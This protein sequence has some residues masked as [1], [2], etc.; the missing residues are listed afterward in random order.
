VKT[1]TWLG[2]VSRG[3]APQPLPGRD[4]QGRRRWDADE[5]RSFPRPGVGRSRAGASPEAEALLAQ[6]REVA[7]AIEELRGRQRE[8]LAEGKRQGL[9]VLA[10]SRALGISRQT[11]YAWLGD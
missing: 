7:D 4:E 1:T 8:L 6:M 11:A 10:M 2:Y 3:Q 5:V 9:E